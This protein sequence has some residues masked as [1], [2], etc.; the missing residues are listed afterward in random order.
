MFEG[1]R[2]TLSAADLGRKAGPEAFVKL[3]AGAYF[4]QRRWRFAVLG[5]LSRRLKFRV[6]IFLEYDCP[7]AKHIFGREDE[8]HPFP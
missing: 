6:K 8:C 7:I 4:A 2:F 5:S 1:T 3:V